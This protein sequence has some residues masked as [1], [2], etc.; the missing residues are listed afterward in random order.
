[1][2]AKAK[3]Q[4]YTAAEREAVLA[5]VARIGGAVGNSNGLVDRILD[6]RRCPRLSCASPC[7]AT[8]GAATA[9]GPGSRVRLLLHA[10]RTQVVP[11]RVRVLAIKRTVI[12]ET[13]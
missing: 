12:S 7:D 2:A 3:R 11:A 5:D 8:A 9:R 1:M 4:R 10:R 13:L 6:I